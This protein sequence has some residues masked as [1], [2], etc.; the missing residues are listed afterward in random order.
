V[1]CF[2]SGAPFRTPFRE[3]P[4]KAG[5]ISSDL[6]GTGPWPERREKTN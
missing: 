2:S 5:L 6:G 1:F 4:Q 3:R